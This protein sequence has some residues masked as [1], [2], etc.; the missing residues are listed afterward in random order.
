MRITR[1][2]THVALTVTSNDRLAREEI[3]AVGLRVGDPPRRRR[4]L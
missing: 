2:K 4:I 3:M 1:V